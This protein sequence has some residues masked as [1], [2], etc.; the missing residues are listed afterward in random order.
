M[1]YCE[2]NSDI[3]RGEVSVQADG[4]KTNRT[5][6]NE[7]FAL[8]DMTKVTYNSKLI[9]GANVFSLTRKGNNF[10]S[11]GCSM[12]ISDI[13][14][15]VTVLNSSTS[16]YAIAVIATNG[17]VSYTNGSYSVASSDTIFTLK[18]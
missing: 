18:Y 16:E 7:L 8:V 5:L 1:L 9:I 10:L 4:V 12:Y 6:L 3:N 14:T 13:R 11:F 2:L 17:T 15:L